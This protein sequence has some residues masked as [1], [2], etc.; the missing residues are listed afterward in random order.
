M[1]AERASFER[2]ASK[3]TL[4]NFH[5]EFART[6]DDRLFRCYSVPG[7][8]RFGLAVEF[9]DLLRRLR[10]QI[11]FLDPCRLPRLGDQP[12]PLCADFCARLIRVGTV[13]GSFLAGRSRVGQQ[14]VRLFLP[15]GDDVHDRP[16]E[17]PGENPDENKDI[18][19]LERQRPPIDVHVLSG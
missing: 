6:S 4:C 18:D 15:L 9:R 7:D 11:C 3:Q 19:G 2:K 16:K 8:R 5:G 13:I 10:E 14:L 1:N 12:V 17:E